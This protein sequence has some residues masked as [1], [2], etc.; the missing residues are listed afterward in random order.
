MDNR[1]IHILNSASPGRGPVVY[2]MS[3][4]QRIHDN[5]ALIHAQELGVRFGRSV[6]V[7]FCLAP[8]FL[9]AA[10][11]QY[12]FMLKGLEIVEKGL[13]KLNIPFY[14]LTGAPEDKIS[15]FVKTKDAGILVT[16]FDPLRIK[17]QW[18]DKIRKKQPFRS[19]KWMRTTLFHAGRYRRS[20][21]TA[22]RQYAEKFTGCFPDS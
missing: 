3:R 18:K 16:D 6:L 7:V 1:R 4:D 11:R 22:R 20:R 10:E 14:L 8:E 12:E 13:H 9:N 19:M 17:R 5:W 2:W 21:N 15:G